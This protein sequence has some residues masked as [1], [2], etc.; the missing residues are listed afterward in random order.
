MRLGL[1]NEVVPADELMPAA[2]RWAEEIL[3]CSPFAVQ[4]SKEMLYSGLDKSVPDAIHDDSR[5][6]LPRL[7]ASKDL[8][9]GTKA[10]VEKRTPQW[11]AR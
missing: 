8:V 10:F 4:L 11:V 9:E 2:V 5:E 7:L 6:R 1:V 3:K